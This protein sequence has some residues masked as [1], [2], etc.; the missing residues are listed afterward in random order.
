MRAVFGA[1]PKTEASP[2][3]ISTSKGTMPAWSQPRG[4]TL[5]VRQPLGVIRWMLE[6]FKSCCSCDRRIDPEARDPD[7]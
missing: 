7:G 1:P 5:E 4:G 2:P 6:W 3:T